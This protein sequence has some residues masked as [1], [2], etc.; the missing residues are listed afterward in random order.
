MARQRRLSVS[1]LR[2]GVSTILVVDDYLDALQVWD[3]YLQAS[4]FKVVTAA[5][6][7]TAMAKA[8]TENPD[9][10]VLDLD[11]PDVSGAEV[12]RYLRARETTR[13]IPTIA[14]T[15]YSQAG[16]LD[17]ARRSGFDLILIKPC[18]PEDLIASIRRLLDRDPATDTATENATSPSR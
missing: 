13:H 2:H 17:E 12:A 7:A 5:D 15:G 11:L 14:V 18:D 9:L 3:L 4:G 16:R 8:T 6:G 10:I 1:P